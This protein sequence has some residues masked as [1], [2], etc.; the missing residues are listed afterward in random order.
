MPATIG[1]PAKRKLGLRFAIRRLEYRFRLQWSWW[2]VPHRPFVPIFVL[3]SQRC[4]S[5]L[6]IDYLNQLSGLGCRGEVLC[7]TVAIGP[8]QASMPPN[9]ALR[10]IQLSLQALK[11]PLRACKLMLNQLANCQLKVDDIQAAF[12]TARYIVLYRQSLAEQFVSLQ[13]ARATRQWQLRKGQEEPKQS[14]IVV[15]PAAL[16]SFCEDQRRAYREVVTKNWLGE[17]ALVVSYEEFTSNPSYWLPKRICPHVGAP[18]CHPAAR[19]LKQNKR[20]LAESVENYTEVAELLT[21]DL[22]QQ[23]YELSAAGT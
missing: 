16:R 22:C 13:T 19:L 11:S 4:G 14:R 15:D 18:P 7:P 1:Q 9:A 3:A 20:T 21:S 12:S 8:K 23:R 5:N 17:R 6:L 10:H 2:L